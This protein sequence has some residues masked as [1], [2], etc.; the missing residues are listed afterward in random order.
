MLNPHNGDF[1][2]TVT[3]MVVFISYHT[4]ACLRSHIARQARSSGC[5]YT[6]DDVQ[7]DT[8]SEQL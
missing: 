1:S 2:L 6:D 3:F 7:E 5:T 4:G 8:V